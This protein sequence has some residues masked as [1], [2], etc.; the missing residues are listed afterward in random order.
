VG[1]L[2]LAVDDLDLSNKM[3]EAPTVYNKG[4]ALNLKSASF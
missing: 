2:K 1:E 4:F 3:E